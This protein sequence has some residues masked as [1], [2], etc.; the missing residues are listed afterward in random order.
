MPNI[1]RP[2]KSQIG[3]IAENQPSLLNLLVAYFVFEWRE[4]RMGSPSHGLDQMG[5]TAVIP[6]FVDTWGVD[7]CVHYLLASPDKRDAD[8][9]GFLSV[10]L[11]EISSE[12]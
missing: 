12:V 7:R 6:D 5:I 11:R 4:V 10:W 3:R 8:G 9:D 1:D 2:T